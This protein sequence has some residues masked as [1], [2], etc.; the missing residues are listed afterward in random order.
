MQIINEDLELL[1]SQLDGQI[2]APELDEPALLRL[3][4]QLDALLLSDL[5]QL[6]TTELNKLKLAYDTY[7]VWIEQFVSRCAAEKQRI[8]DELILLQRRKNATEY[9]QR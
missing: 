9:Y 1:L 5:S 7:L 2:N 4:T 3:V 6:N 8:T